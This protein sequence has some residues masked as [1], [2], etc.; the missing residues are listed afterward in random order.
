MGKHKIVAGYCRVSTLEQKKK[1]YGI[2]IQMREIVGYIEGRGLKIDEFYVDKARSGVTE[3]RRALR[4]LIR[5]C[6]AGR[7]AGVA[8][9]SLDRLSRDLRLTENLLFEFDRARITV[10][11]ADMPYYDAQNRRDVLLRQIREAIAEENRK[12]IIERLKKG[13]EERIR[14]GRMAGG[15]LPYGYARNGKAVAKDPHE[16]EI[17]RITFLLSHSGKNCQEIAAHLNGKGLVR[18]NRKPWTQR[19]VLSV[20][21]RERLYKSGVVKY[22]EIQGDNKDFIIL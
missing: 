9:A 5:D 13:R 17:V 14:K 18:R 3:N 16:V 15:T 19:Q 10:F 4:K 1:G 21:S 20:L 7:I 6:K 8:V 2:D 11:I 12:E 22:G